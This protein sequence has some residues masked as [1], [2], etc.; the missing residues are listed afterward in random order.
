[1]QDE[2]ST[3]AGFYQNQQ[4]SSSK[5]ASR[6]R[7]DGIDHYAA[8]LIRHKARQ[9]VRKAG[10]TESD[11]EDVEQEL[12]LS[13]LLGMPKYNPCRGALSTFITR[14][15]D[16]RVKQLLRF[17]KQEKRDYARVSVS[18]N[19]PVGEE[20]DRAIELWETIDWEATAIRT[21]K[22]HRKRGE[23]TD[24]ALDVSKVLAGVPDDLRRIAECLKTSKSIHEAAQK[25]GVPRTT[26]YGSIGRLRAIFEDAGLRDYL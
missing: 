9:L 8:K 26:L 2:R 14:I 18:L 20:D 16:R 13:V 12:M 6:S 21:G 22:L 1:M 23:E 4:T 19:K 10:Y 3:P 11:I 15:V 17:R 7:A 24:L 25:L 5:E